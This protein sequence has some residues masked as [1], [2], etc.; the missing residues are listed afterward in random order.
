MFSSKYKQKKK[1]VYGVAKRFRR[2][3]TILTGPSRYS[4]PSRSNK[5]IKSFDVV[6][7]DDVTSQQIP[8]PANVAGAQTF[9]TGM[10]AINL[11]PQGSTF[12]NR[13]GSKIVIKSIAIDC[14]VL[15]HSI[16]ELNIVR[17]MI[18]YDRQPNGAYPA[19][20]DIL[21]DNAAGLT[22]TSGVN[23]QNR[24]RF[25]ILRDNYLEINPGSGE[26]KHLK[27]F[28][29][30]SGGLLCEFGTTAGTIGDIK[31]G[32]ILFLMFTPISVNTTGPFASALSLKTRI[33]YDDS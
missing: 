26:F 5:E 30:P 3:P 7:C 17:Y 27:L 10:A 2:T 21:Q 18:V 31:T 25:A 20:A 8:L 1:S 4:R 12:Y 11:V 24:S 9:A 16:A 23:M 29:K 14:G 33:R 6:L 28:V 22:S 32:S 15:A 13:I 19:L